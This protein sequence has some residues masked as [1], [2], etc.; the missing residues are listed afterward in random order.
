MKINI[1][2]RPKIAWL[3]RLFRPLDTSNLVLG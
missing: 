3:L 1:T 2:A